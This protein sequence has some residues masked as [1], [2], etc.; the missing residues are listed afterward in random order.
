MVV[1]QIIKLSIGNVSY[2]GTAS[3]LNYNAGVLPGV[4]SSG[5]TMVL[6]SSLNFSGI[7]QLTVGSLTGLILTPLQ[8]NITSVGTLTSLTISG[9]LNITS[10]GLN[11]LYIDNNKV[12]S[13]STQLN[14][15]S[16]ITL[17]G[18]AVPGQAVVLD[19]IGSISNLNN[20]S[21]NSFLSNSLNIGGF[22][23][24]LNYS[25]FVRND[26]AGINGIRLKNNDITISN[27]GTEIDFSGF[28]TADAN[29]Y[30][31][32]KIRCINTGSGNSIGGAL[33]FFTNTGISPFFNPGTE[34]MRIAPSGFIG[35]NTINPVYR[36]D[37]AD[38]SGNLL[39]LSTNNYNVRFNINNSDGGLNVL[40]PNVN[41]QNISINNVVVTSTPT[42]LNYNT[43]VVPGQALSSRTLI[44]DSNRSLTNINSFSATTINATN[45]LLNSQPLSANATQLNYLITTPGQ[46]NATSALVLDS[47]KSIT[48]MI[49]V[50]NVST[51]RL[52]NVN[53]I[54][55]ANQINVLNTTP[56]QASAVSAVVLD[57]SLNFSGIN[58]LSITRLVLNNGLIFSTSA[59]LNYLNPV[60]IPGTVYPVS[61]VV[62][63][64]NRSVSGFNN[65]TATA[66]YGTIF[67]ASQPN[68]TSVGALNNLRTSGN[69]S[70]NST[71]APNA[72]L[73]I[74]QGAG[75]NRGLRINY[76]NSQLVSSQK[77]SDLTVD[78]SGNL[79]ISS[80]VVFAGIITGTLAP[81]PQV[82]ITSIGT[83]TSLTVSGNIS[84]TI[85][86]TSQPNITSVGIL[87]SLTVSGNLNAVITTASQPNITSVG[88]LTSLNVLGQ[89]NGTLAAG[90]QTGITSVGTL[91]GLT[92]SGS[93]TGQL[94]T[95]SQPNITSLGL[96][97]GLKTSG[98][99][100]INSNLNTSHNLEINQGA[101]SNGVGLRITYDNTVS[102]NSQQASVLKVDSSGILSISSPVNV[103]GVIYG[104]LAPG[105]QT[106]ITSIGTLSALNVQGNIYGNIATSAQPSIT[107][108]GV[109]T[110]LVVA[111]NGTISGTLASGPQAGITSVGTLT[112]LTVTGTI[113]GTLS[114]GPQVGITSI[115]TLS[116][117][118]VSGNISGTLSTASQPNITSVG[119][120]TSLTVSGNLNGTLST[121]SQPN[122]T[123]VGTL[124]SLNV[125][126]NLNAV[127]SNGLQTNITRLGVLDSLTVNGSNVMIGS[128]A[129]SNSNIEI[130]QNAST[131]N[132]GLRINYDNRVALINQ[133]FSQIYV[134]AAGIL[135]VSSALF[136][137][138]LISGQIATA[139]QPNI[140][141]LG[142]LQSLNTIGNVMINSSLLANSSLEINQRQGTS[143]LRL[144][145]DN[146]IVPV[147]S[148]KFVNLFSDATGVLQ[149]SGSITAPS[150]S[151]TILTGSQPNITSI[152]TLT[153]LSVSG[154]ISG[155][156]ITPSQI[157]IT[158]VG[159]LNAL[160]VSNALTA[161]S[162]LSNANIST[163]NGNIGIGTNSPST[164]LNIV[165]SSVNSCIL[166]TYTPGATTYSVSIYLD[167]TGS[168][169]FTAPLV[170]PNNSSGASAT[171]SDPFLTGTITLNGTALS[172]TAGQI[173]LLSGVTAGTITAGRVVI[174][175]SD[176]NISNI[177]TL[178]A[179]AI[180]GT[181]LTAFQPS[182]TSV[183]TLTSLTVS[184]NIN[185]TITTAS[186]P[187]IT[188]VGVLQGGN[189]VSALIT[190]GS[191]LINSSAAY[192]ATSSLEINQGASALGLKLTYD[193]T[194]GVVKSSTIY[195]DNSSTL[196]VSTALM[197]AGLIYGTLAP[198]PQNNI[199]S[200]G[201]LTSLTV[202]GNITLGG[203]LIAANAV[204]LNYNASV[205]PGTVLAGSTVVV[206]SLRNIS[207]F[208]N[209]Y[210]TGSLFLSNVK[211]NATANEINYLNSAMPGMVTANLAVIAG[212]DRSISN[213][214][215]L[216]AGNITGIIQTNTQPSITSIGNLVGLNVLTSK[217]GVG[218]SIMVN[219][220][221][222]P[223][224]LLE[225]NQGSTNNAL[226]LTYDNTATTIRS[227]T[228]YT[229]SSGNLN[230]IGPVICNSTISGTLTTS[231]QNNITSIGTLSSL[232]VSGNIAGTLSTA[233]QPNITSIGTLSSLNITGSLGLGTSSPSSKL[234]IIQSSAT[235][236]MN[237]S[238]SSNTA[239]IFIDATGNLNISTPLICG[240]L[241]ATL[242]SGPQ[243][244][245][246]AVGTLSSLNVSGN[247]SGTLTTA[248]QTNITSVG[249]LSAL[250]VLGRAYVNTS[251]S[252]SYVPTA[253][254]EI[255]QG[256]TTINAG[257]KI[258]YDNTVSPGSVRAS[259][260][261]TDG[262]GAL[263]IIS[264][265]IVQGTISGVLSSGPQNGITSVGVLT[266]LTTS[267]NALIN[268]TSPFATTNANLEVNQ[269]GTIT[270]AGIRITYNSTKFSQIY[271]DSTGSLNILSP[272]IIDS[273]LVISNGSIFG[274][275]SS[276]SQP[277]IT[278]LGTLTS[279]SVSGVITAGGINMGIGNITGSGSISCNTLTSNSTLTAGSIISQG[280]INAGN[281]NIF[282]T[283]G[284]IYT[285]SGSICVGTST[286]AINANLTI[287]QSSSTN[288]ITLKY[289]ANS[290]AIYLDSSGKF[291]F[292]SGVVLPGSSSQTFNNPTLTGDITIGS[293]V[294]SSSAIKLNYLQNSTPGTASASSALVLDGS[295]DITNIN[296]ITATNLTATN[297]TGSILTASQP[298]ITS[299]GTLTGL[300][301]SGG[302]NLSNNAGL[303]SF[304][305][306]SNTNSRILNIS[307][308]Y[309]AQ[310]ISGLTSISVS[311]G[312]QVMIV[313]YISTGAV[314]NTSL[315]F[316]N[317]NSNI[318]VL[319]RLWVNGICI[320]NSGVVTGFDTTNATTTNIS[321]T[322]NS[323]NY[324]INSRVPICFQ[325]VNNSATMANVRIDY[326]GTPIT[327][328]SYGT[329]AITPS[330]AITSYV[331]YSRINNLYSVAEGIGSAS[332]PLILDSTSS[333]AS[334]LTSLRA[335]GTVL[336]AK[337]GVNVASVSNA[338]DVNGTIRASGMSTPT[339][340]AGIELAYNSTNSTSAIY[341]FNRTSRTF[342]NLNLNDRFQFTANYQICYGS[343]ATVPN[344]RFDMGSYGGIYNAMYIG[345]SSTKSFGFGSDITNGVLQLQSNNVFTFFTGSTPSSVG[346][347]CMSLTSSPITTATA[348]TLN[349]ANINGLIV[350]AS[351]TNITSVG[352]LTSL[353][354]GGALNTNGNN[355]TM[356]S[357]NIT[358]TGL[359][360]SGS[361][362]VSGVI[363]LGGTA[364]TATAAQLNYL[365]GSTPGSG[366][367]S[368]A[369][370]LDSSKNIIGINSITASNLNITSTNASTSSILGSI[371]TAG[372]IS[373]SNATS[374]TSATNGGSF[375]TAGGIGVSGNSHFG[376]SI[377]MSGGSGIFTSNCSINATNATTGA[378]I[379]SGGICIN[380]T[381]NNATSLTNGGSIVSNGGMGIS[382]NVYFGSNLNI[383][384][385]G[386]VTINNT[387]GAT[388]LNTG[389][390]VL[391]TG[392]IYVGNASEVSGSFGGSITTAGGVYIGK[393][394]SIG[395]NLIMGSTSITAS[396]LAVLS[397]I[398]GY[399][400]TVS[401][402]NFLSGTTAG[403]ASANSALILDGSLNAI[404]INSLTSSTLISG[405]SANMSISASVLAS[406]VQFRTIATTYLNN[407]TA[408][409][410]VASLANISFLA[411]S[412]LSTVSNTA[413]TTTNASTLYIAGPP[414]AG[415][416]MTITNPYSLHIPTGNVMIGNTFGTT[417]KSNATVCIDF[418]GNATNRES[419]G[420]GLMLTSGGSIA[421]PCMYM[422]IDSSRNI[423]Y[424]QSS[425]IGAFV[426]MCLNPRG[427]NIGIGLFSPQCALDVRTGTIRA[428]GFG[429]PASGAGLELAYSPG[430]GAGNILAYDR[431]ELSY[432][433]IN[434][435]DRFQFIRDGNG[436]IIFG[437]SAVS[438]T[439]NS[440]GALIDL[441]SSP[442]NMH[443]N[444]HS[445]R[446]GLGAC[447][448]SLQSFSSENFTWYRSTG[449]ISGISTPP[450]SSLIMTLIGSTGNL[451]ILTGSPAYTLDVNGSI[452]SGGTL[453]VGD[454][455]DNSSSRIIS[456]LR[457]NLE[458][459]NSGFI[460]FGQSASS[461]NQAELMFTYTGSGSSNN[462]FQVGFFGTL[463]S[464]T[465]T[466]N[467]KVGINQTSPDFPLHVGNSINGTYSAGTGYS[468][469]GGS[470][471]GTG[472]QP[473]SAC[474]QSHVLLRSGAVIVSSDI[475][476][477]KNI[478]II[479][480]DFAKTFINTIEPKRFKYLENDGVFNYGFVA[481]DLCKNNYYDLLNTVPDSGIPELEM[482][483]IT[484]KKDFSLT[485]NYS[486]IAPLLCKTTR[487]LYK[488]V[489]DLKAENVNMKAEMEKLKEQI[490]FIMDNIAS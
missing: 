354:M 243:T 70:I 255:N 420:H 477:K 437:D 175:G 222:A 355:I 450:N 220:T 142:N 60:V 184:G 236:G 93:I 353:T 204:Q 320:T 217:Y 352:T 180:N 301:V 30:S 302:L 323:T 418:E 208:N 6:D 442:T 313:G 441:G 20:V 133:K 394:L 379:L 457:S 361:L 453:L 431:T 293:T 241:T 278:S 219:S 268:G 5:K 92:V 97:T 404:G 48:G 287:I 258:S 265:L 380:G 415:T 134:D 348:M 410:G 99:V 411:S 120:L 337:L 316:T 66:F 130:N 295:R 195:V 452:R 370:V 126:G 288:C 27:A 78:S 163:V 467:G 331:H 28:N 122:I 374:A 3:Q 160:T 471:Y 282:T 269:N 148:Q 198:G 185:G 489:D 44:V 58:E 349:V 468:S 244:G 161:G 106:G 206:D 18:R 333:I 482:D 312:S 433:R 203:V 147:A 311:T 362:T 277:N 310:S 40:A 393:S 159:T 29:N 132:K 249:T 62:T 177:A 259:T 242:A 399:T 454:S 34:Q 360:T 49:N 129:V 45:I 487:D 166:M 234:S 321:Y 461:N 11:G 375:T 36:L 187:N 359:L 113:S 253:N 476:K 224:Q 358:T 237:L 304:T 381:N 271:T 176:R 430:N 131:S 264:P 322:L 156:L 117:L 10:N 190:G 449:T 226:K 83:L 174:A 155:T 339:S 77:F 298:A 297:L 138:G 101:T 221:L 246:T 307:D 192:N 9:G 64:S 26:S 444:L 127:L 213:I 128:S 194:A 344:A 4:A 55:T 257:L 343:V 389:A 466:A 345:S 116:S 448:N 290:S 115:G 84:G 21:A 61:A 144:T 230:I 407:S 239:S 240:V 367:A 123:S 254:L 421:N 88:T 98:N 488:Q 274:V 483:G 108:L 455:T 438:T 81:G 427:G 327:G 406:G 22:T 292:S 251:P 484:Y 459:G 17:I 227:I 171:L 141:S 69:V 196:Q 405:S 286:P 428:Q 422:G 1:S 151:G 317:I 39:R 462:K 486:A 417:N 283:G 63:D 280:N 376:S 347:V 114:P 413:V 285:T 91:Q 205:V 54:T 94:S 485:V 212:A 289:G 96:L 429:A 35:I 90:P 100:I 335:T 37:I 154:N 79:N 235:S 188:K 364:L 95:A 124:T 137:N 46:A 2:S 401:A 409:S 172:A 408:S 146:T 139:S 75:L 119:T 201:S 153:S 329:G 341:S 56:G 149:I 68:I 369:L 152:G 366:T 419:G 262:S 207:G 338:L 315:R 76:D 281:N 425:K 89:I 231:V 191:V 218:A 250:R 398:S 199:T 16:N 157:N 396:N 107:S 308:N 168:L 215:S 165:Q 392:G 182:I 325:I 300:S 481:Q 183:G 273:N 294:L 67:T 299:I 31:L 390:I 266:G 173:N 296:S 225:I 85:S 291:N 423:S 372:G 33:T 102:L 385:S 229:D 248:A 276:G 340:G 436:S 209:V 125:S 186:Q 351:Q 397:L 400:G 118:T 383:A 424:I 267:G 402:L 15:L 121:A 51:L 368:N 74:N 388:S 445:G 447:N 260:L 162:I 181:I 202:S 111:S 272:V 416:N 193:N 13:T 110:S 334:G 391:P 446:F 87:N 136:V 472:T 263:N 412:T 357:G 490:K 223:T 479:D 305:F 365:F 279:L 309:T 41:F 284:N 57:G 14:Y 52:N 473:I 80:P 50:L 8:P 346:T 324:P 238:F 82:G 363:T 456:A 386:I 439:T 43:G 318:S 143:G 145:Y 384:S 469:T 25:I 464:F 475:R 158:S 232:T 216:T 135:N 109:L 140:T 465:V 435:S 200:I 247:I 105:P 463:P 319:C 42:E 480:L 150:F 59:Q 326:A 23:N 377:T 179:N 314:Q 12:L 169:N 189:G 170:F 306:S 356:G 350:Q 112:S 103:L 460:T 474:F 261:Y 104:T 342:L 178:T 451:G 332:S 197:C 330:S 38:N 86:T 252:G 19:N 24:T 478:E 470:S 164:K 403:T 382:G 228:M 53:V 387:S 432:K 211:I 378:I 71:I 270:D 336:C 434:I 214:S 47:N 32:A 443:V 303:Y 167:S 73:E 275:L 72:T 245:I 328:F 210:L 256:A 371:T 426:A 395:T 7:N 65:I 414:I 373:I 440:C 233:S 458:V